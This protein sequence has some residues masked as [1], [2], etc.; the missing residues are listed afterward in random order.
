[1]HIE[2]PDR[3]LSERRAGPYI[4]VVGK[5]GTENWFYLAIPTPVIVNG[6]ILDKSQRRETYPS[7]DF[8]FLT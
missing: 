7:T 5:P 6:G 8:L 2:Y 3:I 4:Q 1:M